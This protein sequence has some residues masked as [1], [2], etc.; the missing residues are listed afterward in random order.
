LIKIKI[1]YIFYNKQFG[2]FVS[3][4][5]INDNFVFFTLF[6]AIFVHHNVFPQSVLS[7]TVYSVVWNVRVCN[8][9]TRVMHRR[10]HS[11]INV[12]IRRTR[13]RRVPKI[14]AAPCIAA[15][16]TSGALTICFAS[17][18]LFLILQTG[19]SMS[20]LTR[21]RGRD[22]S[23]GVRSAIPLLTVRKKSWPWNHC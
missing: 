6:K 13:A 12:R 8:G 15:P 20:G 11:V 10:M 17:I 7:W 18:G 5:F 3:Q 21:Y 9:V 2:Y 1:R 19:S 23:I 4:S 22:L 16:V 14:H